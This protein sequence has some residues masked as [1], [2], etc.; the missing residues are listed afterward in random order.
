MT[1]E[2]KI[3]LLVG[4]AFIIVIGVLLSDHIQSSTEPRRA[5]LTA[6]GDTLRRGIEV[7]G[8]QGSKLVQVVAPSVVE[9]SSTV[10]TQDYLTNAG[11]PESIIRIGPGNDATTAGDRNGPVISGNDPVVVGPQIQLPGNTPVVPLAAEGPSTQTQHS[12][13]VVVTP[14]PEQQIEDVI[15]RGVNRPAAPE[16]NVVA[17]GSRK[18]VAVEGDSVYRMTMKYYGGYSK[19]RELLIVKANPTMGGKAERIVIGQTYTIPSLPGTKPVVDTSVA[20]RAQTARETLPPV[21]QTNTPAPTP[22]REPVAPA[23]ASTYTVRDGDSLW[24]IADRTGSSINEIK[25]MNKDL[26]KGGDVVRPGMTLR[27]PAKPAS[28]AVN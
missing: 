12:G 15:G 4:L 7:P 5:V 19:S 18:H 2:T 23:R 1:R 28:A 26:L 17:D 16:N 3:G 8:G 13:A 25:S 14:S 6:S 22:V 21:V 24:K 11:R 27:L 10:V 20:D 9:P